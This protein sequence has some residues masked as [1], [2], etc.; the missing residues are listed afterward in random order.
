MT[1]IL[2]LFSFSLF[3]YLLLYFISGVIFNYLLY[4][5]FTFMVI[6]ISIID[7]K[8]KVVPFLLS[9]YRNGS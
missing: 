3:K 6:A 2:F 1:I 9:I 7:K 4:F 5:L 8:V